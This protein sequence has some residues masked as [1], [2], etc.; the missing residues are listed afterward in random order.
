MFNFVWRQAE[1]CVDAMLIVDE[2]R[3]A[4]RLYLSYQTIASQGL[5]KLAVKQYEGLP[6]ASRLAAAFFAYADWDAIANDIFSSADWYAY[7][8]RLANTSMEEHGTE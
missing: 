8:C 3:M 2:E 1:A 4:D 7:L 5:M 6:G